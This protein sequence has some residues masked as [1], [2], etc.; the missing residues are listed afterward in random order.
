MFK[1][2]DHFK[3]YFN[4]INNHKE[5]TPQETP[6]NTFYR[7]SL[8]LLTF[9]FTASVRPPSDYPLP[10]LDVTT[11]VIK[12]LAPD[13]KTARGRT[14]SV[15][16]RRFSSV[17]KGGRWTFCLHVHTSVTQQTAVFFG[18]QCERDS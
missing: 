16:S 4:Q 13:L 14:D 18:L 3:K 8:F 7:L 12:F 1:V 2:D 9:L 10:P 6:V 17:F 15:V 5:I 11:A